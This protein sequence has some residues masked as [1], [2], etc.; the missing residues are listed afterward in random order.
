MIYRG[1]SLLFG[2][3]GGM[4]AGKV[5]ALI[6]QKASGQDEP[7]RPDDQDFNWR[8][9]L[10]AATL[11]GAVFGLVRAAVQRAGAQDVRK[12]TGSWPGDD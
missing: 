3:L 4:L 9:I 12:V 11:Q 8:Q 1:L 7:P 5:F 2:S 6:W 10:I